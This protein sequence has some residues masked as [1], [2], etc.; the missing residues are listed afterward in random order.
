MVNMSKAQRPGKIINTVTNELYDDIDVIPVTTKDSMLNGKTEA[1]VQV[2]LLLFMMQIVISL[3]K[4][5]EIK[6]TKIDY[7]MVT[8]LKTLLI[9]LYCYVERTQAQH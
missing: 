3:V 7:Q 2:L 4:R 5:L 6:L 8:I 9:I 1:Q